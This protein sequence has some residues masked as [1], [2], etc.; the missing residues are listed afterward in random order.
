MSFSFLHAPLEEGEAATFLVDEAGPFR[1]NSSN[2]LGILGVS[3]TI[4]A[5]SSSETGD[6]D[7]GTTG[8][9]GGVV[10]LRTALLQRECWA[11]RYDI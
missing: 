11:A 7:R 2:S 4:V 6:V 8:K 5:W 10:C 3:L 1:P 9:V